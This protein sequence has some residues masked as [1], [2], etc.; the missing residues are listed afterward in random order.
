MNPSDFSKAL[1]KIAA[2]IEK[3]GGGPP[4]AEEAPAET[5]A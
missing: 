1:R 4:A 5:A 2:K 3:D